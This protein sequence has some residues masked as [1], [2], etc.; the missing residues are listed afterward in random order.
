MRPSVVIAVS[1]TLAAA[2]FA[3]V[4]SL[5]EKLSDRRAFRSASSGALG[6][7]VAGAAGAVSSHRAWTRATKEGIRASLGQCLRCGYDL[8]ASKDRCPECGEPTPAAQLSP[9]DP[10]P[11][12]AVKRL[13][14]HADALARERGD[15]HVGT[16][17]VLLALFREPDGVA[18]AV[19]ENLGVTEDEACDE[20]A[21]LTAG[22]T[23]AATTGG[24]HGQTGGPETDPPATP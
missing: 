2:G 7:G 16:E 14:Q 6:F 1:V 18:A 8:R 12:P 17:H 11:T 20:V 22:L 3:I 19:L 4:M 13:L 23:P 21:E 24:G 10:D 9:D 5:S 15:K